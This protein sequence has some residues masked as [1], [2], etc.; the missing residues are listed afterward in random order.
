MD[1]RIDESVHLIRLDVGEKIQEKLKAYVKENGIQ[2]GFLT[3]IG[4]ASSC[5]IGYY[6]IVKKKYLPTLIDEMCEITSIVGNISWTGDEPVI[7]AHITLG[8]SDMSTVGGHLI[9]GIIGITGEF[10]IYTAPFRVNR[11]PSK[12]EGLKLIDFRSQ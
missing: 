9:E 11:T 8:K 5:E 6:D 3:G 12:F 1:S 2:S 7:H 4:A 10:W